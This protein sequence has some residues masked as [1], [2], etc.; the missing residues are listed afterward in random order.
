LTAIESALEAQNVRAVRAANGLYGELR[1]LIGGSDHRRVPFKGW[2]VVEPA[3]R[4]GVRF[5]G[6]VMQRDQVIKLFV[7]TCTMC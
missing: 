7:C 6:C 4:S 5:S 1:C 2:V 3:F